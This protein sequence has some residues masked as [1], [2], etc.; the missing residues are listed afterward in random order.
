[1]KREEFD[2]VITILVPPEDQAVSPS[3]AVLRCPPLK[4]AAENQAGA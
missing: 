2:K 4:L 1:M 3:T